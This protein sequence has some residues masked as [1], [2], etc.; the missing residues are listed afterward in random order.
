MVGLFQ[1]PIRVCLPHDQILW[2][3]ENSGMCYRRVPVNAL[4]QSCK[5]GSTMWVMNNEGAVQTKV[6]CYA[7]GKV[8][9]YG[10]DHSNSIK[11]KSIKHNNV[12]RYKFTLL[13]FTVFSIS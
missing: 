3:K 1:L 4:F 9:K 10:K 7:Y 8:H 12:R 11:S 13:I 2:R 6:S 5:K